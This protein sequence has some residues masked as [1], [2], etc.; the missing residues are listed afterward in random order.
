MAQ[1]A[2]ASA[3]MSRADAN[4][5]VTRLVDKYANSLKTADIGQAFPQLYDMETL[6]PLNIWEGM[7]FDVCRE[8]KME[9]GLDL[10][11]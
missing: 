11:V 5:I 8:F 2:R 4:P 7:Y 9:F 1:A 6:K 3:G 10:A